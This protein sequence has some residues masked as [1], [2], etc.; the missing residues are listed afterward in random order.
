MARSANVP[1]LMTEY[2]SVSCGGSNVSDTVIA[3]IVVLHY[4]LLNITT[5]SPQHCGPS[6][7]RSNL[8]RMD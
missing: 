7:S 8:L 4:Q 1:V 6:T 5:S 2:N 3:P